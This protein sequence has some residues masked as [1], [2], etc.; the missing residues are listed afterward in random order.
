VRRVVVLLSVVFSFLAVGA[1]AQ[2]PV[3]AEEVW[4][5]VSRHRLH[6]TLEGGFAVVA[7]ELVLETEGTVHRAPTTI[8]LRVPSSAELVAI[9]ACQGGQCRRGSDVHDADE[10][11]AEA[12]YGY[13]TPG[14]PPL[15]IAERDT[16]RIT[17]RVA[18]LEEGRAEVRVLW[19]APTERLGGL[20]RL[21][22]PARETDAEVTL[23]SRSLDGLSIDRDPS[24]VRSP[25]GRAY[26]L[27][28][29]SD[30]RARR[31]E[32]G[33]I[34]GTG[35]GWVRAVAP[36]SPG[37]PRHVAILL[38]ASPSMHEHEA[39]R[40]AA[41]ESLLDVVPAG[42]RVSIVAFARRARL[43]ADGPIESLRAQELTIPTDL[44]PSTSLAAALQTLE[45]VEGSGEATLLWLGDG[46][47]AWGTRERRAR[48]ELASRGGRVITTDEHATT[49]VSSISVAPSDDPLGARARLSALFLPTMDIDVGDRVLRVPAGEARLVWLRDVG[50]ARALA[51]RSNVPAEAASPL[52]RAGLGWHRPRTLITLDPRDRHAANKTA[53]GELGIFVAGGGIEGAGPRARIIVC[54]CGWG[55]GYGPRGDISREMIHRMMR[56]VRPAVT[57]CF[58]HARRG[59]PRYES[60]AT[61]VLGFE[62]D[63]LAHANVETDDPALR[64]CMLA[65]LDHLV[66]PE[67]PAGETA[68]TILRYPFVT[69]P[70][71]AAAALPIDGALAASLDAAF[72]SEPTV[73]PLSL[74]AIP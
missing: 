56:S 21:R 17:L 5:E 33:R 37:S 73:P 27:V 10:V 49:A 69:Q 1:R 39:E 11:F 14:T 40:A 36:S 45:G 62:G 58:A 13:R 67:L 50:P 8:T 29:Q 34:D 15:V 70:Y 57:A 53:R 25:I 72:A 23:V 63:E 47:L 26:D 74:F 51:A 43:L 20:E 6:A 28:G 59:D 48:E 4:V 60:R 65:A 30:A 55:D 44:G 42:S 22:M 12:Q 7:E 64:E 68:R 41:L 66:V 24:L 46:G 38:D 52:V 32:V 16:T 19:S 54:R 2:A 3:E 9:E 61:Y 35:A 31:V 18:G 71:E